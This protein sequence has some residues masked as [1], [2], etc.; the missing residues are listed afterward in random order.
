MTARV[1]ALVGCGARKLDHRAPA[2]AL[3]TGSLFVATMR[4]AVKVAA[5][6]DVWILSAKYGLVAPDTEIDPYD[7]KLSDLSSNERSWWALRVCDDLARRYGLSRQRQTFPKPSGITFQIFAGEAYTSELA[8][9]M[10]WG[11]TNG[12]YGL[13]TPLG[14]LTMGARMH[15]LKQA[16]IGGA[17]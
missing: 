11:A 4:H 17:P 5:P 13:V 16:Q 9:Q 15:W 3:Y 1:V 7:V 10:R 8:A 2:G 6:G 12:E 14:G